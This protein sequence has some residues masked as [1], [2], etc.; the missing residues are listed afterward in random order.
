MQMMEMMEMMMMMTMLDD[1]DDDDAAD[2]DVDDESADRF[3]LPRPWSH[4]GSPA[5]FRPDLQGVSGT[6][7]HCKLVGGAG[8]APL[9]N[10]DPFFLSLAVC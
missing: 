8:V 2:D 9:Q 10:F 4:L 3:F 5:A 7:K 1:D 6:K